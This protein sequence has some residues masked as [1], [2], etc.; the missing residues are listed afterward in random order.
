MYNLKVETFPG[1]MTR[2]NYYEYFVSKEPHKRSVPEMTENPF[3]DKKV[4]VVKE[5][6]FEKDKERSSYVSMQRSKKMVYNYALSNEWDWFVTMTFNPKKVNRYDYASCEKALKTFLDATR[7]IC[8]GMRYIFVPELHED[9]A[10]HFHG[11]LSD[12]PGLQFVFSGKIKNRRRIFNIPGYRYGFTTA[13]KVSDSRKS[14][15]YLCK[16]I[17]KALCQVSANKKRYWTSRNLEL[18]AVTEAVVILGPNQDDIL[19]NIYDLCSFYKRIE[20]PYHGKCSH[21]FEFPPEIHFS[22]DNFARWILEY[23]A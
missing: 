15:G 3:D 18:P 13:T 14:A 6:S 7:R 23:V 19:D 16:Y 5:F 4:R 10:F 20:S 9:G 1:G 2:V 11:L 22:A 12:C 17:T 8:P 21:F